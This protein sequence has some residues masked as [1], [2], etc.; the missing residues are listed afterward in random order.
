MEAELSA[1]QKDGPSV[2]KSD[3]GKRIAA[4]ESLTRKFRAVVNEE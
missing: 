3:D 2:L 1:W 4:D